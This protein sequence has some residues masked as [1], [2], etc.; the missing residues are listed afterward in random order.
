[1]NAV[2]HV[3]T[4]TSTQHQAGNINQLIDM[5]NIYIYKLDIVIYTFNAN[6]PLTKSN[7]PFLGSFPRRT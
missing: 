2:F 3:R 1:M 7:G 5:E 4:D 6:K